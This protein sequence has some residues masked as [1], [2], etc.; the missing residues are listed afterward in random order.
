MIY[1]TEQK[2]HQSK[3]KNLSTDELT[4]RQE[5]AGSEH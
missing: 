3:L 1:S 5:L 4:Q 2:G